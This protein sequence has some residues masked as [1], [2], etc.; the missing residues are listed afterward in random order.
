MQTIRRNRS[1]HA[2]APRKSRHDEMLSRARAVTASDTLDLDRRFPFVMDRAE[3]AAVWDVDGNRFVDLTSCSGA[4]PLGAGFRPV[5][6]RVNA[7]TL[8]TGGILPGPISTLRVE[9]AERL[10]EV[11]PCAERAVFYR[12]GSCATTA[13]VRFAR[14][15]S[16]KRMVLT[17]GYHGWHD[18]HLQY[19]PKLALPDR[20]H[21]VIDFGYDLEALEELLSRHDPAAAVIVTPEVN[22]F[23]P[24]YAQELQAITKRAGALLVID[25]VM[26]GFRFGRGGY[27]GALGLEP[28][29]ITVS[30][31]LANGMALSAVVGRGDVLRAQDETHT[32][33]TY[34]REVTPFAAAL[35]TLDHWADGSA[36]AR[37]RGVGASLMTGLN[38]LFEQYGVAAAAFAC[39]SMFDMVFAAEAT[40]R[41]FCQEMWQR[42]FLMQYGGRF[43][44]S[45]ATTDED[46]AAA[47]QA[48]SGALDA[49]QREAG[50][51][52]EG[53]ELRTFKTALVPFAADCFAA[54]QRTVERWSPAPPEE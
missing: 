34:Q 46:V 28:D 21:D 2:T 42:G 53:H 39:P 36:L 8:R 33:N 48:A 12:T 26:T 6:D 51:K 14:I 11:F 3:G 17:S 54:T 18:W 5:L 38:D 23:P 15:H 50:C 41:R 29:L 1:S 20:D 47:L 37:V 30:K 7:E 49:I 44:P 31:G 4:A 32:G 25:E 27:H 35:A 52:E 9:V 10:V 16:K 22:F 45:A 43:M 24:R 13:A 19:R 40:G